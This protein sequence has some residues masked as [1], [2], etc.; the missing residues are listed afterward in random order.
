MD[1]GERIVVGTRA[2]PRPAPSRG[3][4]LLGNWR[5]AVRVSVGNVGVAEAANHLASAPEHA[6]AVRPVC[7]RSLPV[8]RSDLTVSWW[9]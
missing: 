8:T 4:G 1:E 9:Q 2:L 5:W 6:F 7:A 3:C